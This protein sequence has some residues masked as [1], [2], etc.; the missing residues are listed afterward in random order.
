MNTPS[1]VQKTLRDFVSLIGQNGKHRPAKPGDVKP[2]WPDPKP[3]SALTAGDGTV[4]WQVEGI[5]ARG[6]C[7]LTSALMKAGKSTYLGTMLRHMQDGTPFLG[8]ATKECRTLVVS[9]ESETIWTMRR[10]ALGLDDHLH[11]LAKPMAY[12][13]SYGDW[14]E[15][16]EFVAAKAADRKCDVV[17]FDTIGK[18]APWENENDAAQVQGTVNPLDQLT[19][20]GLGVTLFHHFGKTDGTEGRA[21]RGSTALTGAVDIILELRRYKPDDKADR[22]RVLSGLGRF[23]T[24][25]DEIVLA[26]NDDGTDYTSHG[27]K[28]A[29]AAREL[30]AAL[31]DALPD[32]PP[33]RT[34]D[35]IHADLDDTDRPRRGDV[36]KALRA[37]V[38]AG[39]WRSTGTGKRGFPYRF[40]GSKTD[41][42]PAVPDPRN[43]IGKEGSG[44]SVPPP[45]GADGTEYQPPGQGYRPGDSVPKES[46]TESAADFPFGA[47]RQPTRADLDAHAASH[48]GRRRR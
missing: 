2:R 38:T 40:W 48:H 20:A 5:L 13:P 30:Q 24:I 15:F 1:A 29:E 23:D 45:I 36:M 10:D 12:K 7:T 11:V 46:G 9:E 32:E 37:G 27:D 4:D 17:V 41:S 18:F 34:A 42:V 16:V 3:V 28:K 21:A 44:Y 26:L 6:H 33:G 8:R 14:A 25:P 35:E 43:R 39:K 19:Q 31:R 47:N 22:R